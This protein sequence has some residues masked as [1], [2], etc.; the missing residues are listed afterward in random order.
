MINYP[1]KFQPILK[2]KIWGGEKLK[3]ILNKEST[4]KD[5]GE[6]WE[7]STVNGEISKVVN[8][9]LKGKSLLELIKTYKGD[10][11][12]EKVYQEFGNQFPLLIKYIDAKEALSIQL[13]PNDTLAQKRHDSFGKTEMWYVMQ[14]DKN[15]NL[16]VGFNQEVT[17]EEYLKYLENK[18]LI[19]ILNFDIVKKSDVYFIPT[20][21]VHAIGAG[22]LL[23]EIQQTSDITYRIYDW[24]RQDNQGNYRD[25]HTEEALDALDFSVKEKYNT[26]YVKEQNKISNI[27]D[28][29][30]FTTN[31]LPID[32]A[33]EIDNS[34]KNSFVIYMCVGGE[35]VHLKSDN[36]EEELKLGETILLPASI[37]NFKIIPLGNSE[38]LEVYIS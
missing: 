21:R 22:V 4:R 17:K 8:G 9:S 36:F 27:I 38:L 24:N 11:L 30:Y 12:G 16:N 26:E 7:I 23:A 5:I 15:A 18:K 31:I 29:Q 13:H 14:A 32:S 35:G 33:I 25:L 6:S 34:A 28:C 10:L 19:E 20:G 1:L 2:D 37:N 3:N